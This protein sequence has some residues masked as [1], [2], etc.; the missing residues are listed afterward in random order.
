[1]DARSIG[2]RGT[3]HWE[4]SLRRVKV[5]IR[6]KGQGAEADKASGTQCRLKGPSNTTVIEWQT[7]IRWDDDDDDDDDYDDYDDQCWERSF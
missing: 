4:R 7:G 3:D 1:M 5:C 6:S 2:Y